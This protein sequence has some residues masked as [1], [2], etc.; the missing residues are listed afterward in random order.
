MAQ[1][2]YLDVST[3][4]NVMHK[5]QLRTICTLRFRCNDSSGQAQIDDPYTLFFLRRILS[6]TR[7]HCTLWL[8]YNQSFNRLSGGYNYTLAGIALDHNLPSIENLIKITTTKA[9]LNVGIDTFGFFLCHSFFFTH[10]TISFFLKSSKLM[11]KIETWSGRNIFF[12]NVCI[13]FCYMI[14]LVIIK[15]FEIWNLNTLSCENFKH[16]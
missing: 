15:L 1:Q 6:C 5:M 12:E 13:P 11:I 7:T 4:S 16:S 9:S 10:N 8:C 14:P 3:L 2:V